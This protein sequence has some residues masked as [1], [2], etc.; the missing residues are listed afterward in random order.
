MKNVAD[1]IIVIVICFGIL[2]FGLAYSVLTFA[3]DAPIGLINNQIDTGFLSADTVENFNLVLNLWKTLPIIFVLGLIIFCYERA[4]GTSIG[5]SVFFEYET[6]LILSVVF[7]TYFVYIYGMSADQIFSALD[8]TEIIA[9]IDP[10]WE[11]SELKV[12][13]I[14]MMYNACLIP[15]FLGSLLYLIHPI[16]RQTDNTYS[17]YGSDEDDGSGES[18][19]TGEYVTPYEP[20]QFQ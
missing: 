3:Y 9:N 17:F 16:L 11:T 2:T 7:S 4:K 18:S 12:L 1:S 15:G 20:L 13:M 6:L 5:A 14:K 19:S 10:R 8:R